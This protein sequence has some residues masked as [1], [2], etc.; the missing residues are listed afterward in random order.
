MGKITLDGQE[1]EY[2]NGVTLDQV[3][4]YHEKNFRPSKPQ[5]EK[6]S[7]GS[8]K[9]FSKG[10]LGQARKSRAG[11]QEFITGNPV[12]YLEQSPMQ[13]PQELWHE[14][15]GSAAAHL[16]KTAIGIGAGSKLGAPFGPMGRAVGGILGAFGS[17]YLTQ[18]GPRFGLDRLGSGAEGAIEALTF[19]TGHKERFD[20]NKQIREHKKPLAGFDERIARQEA[21]LESAKKFTEREKSKAFVDTGSS[22]VEALTRK[23]NEAK[24]ELKGLPSDEAL[25]A[26]DVREGR[27]ILPALPPEKGMGPLDI[28]QKNV[29][30]HEDRLKNIFEPKE[31]MPTHETNINEIMKSEL[32]QKQAALGS[33]YQGFK[34]QHEGRVIKDGYVKDANQIIEELPNPD[35]LQLFGYG[36]ESAEEQA[37]KVNQQLV[38]VTKDVNSLFDNWRSLKRYAQRARGKARA[39]GEDISPD[40]RNSLLNA[41][42]KYDAAASKLEA[43]LKDNGY[44]QSLNKIKDLN[45][46]YANEY[47]PIYDTKAFWYMQKEGKAPPNF[48]NAI[49]GNVRGKE[50]LRDIVKS[51][52]DLLKSSLGQ[53]IKGDP[54]AALEGDKKALLNPYI[55][56]HAASEP[57]FKKLK[58]SLELLPVA[59]KQHTQLINEATRIRTAGDE[60]LKNIKMKK[61]VPVQKQQLK[62]TISK[63]DEYISRLTRAISE[64]ENKSRALNATKAEKLRAEKKI[65]EL[66]EQKDKLGVIKNGLLLTFGTKVVKPLSKIITGNL[67]KGGK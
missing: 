43:T 59:E 14:K 48:L 25:S 21:Q 56:S 49:E 33:E 17:Q 66:K 32:K 3:K 61:E 11:L 1:Y 2:G 60:I 67:K 42:S 65:T 22:K 18:P 20:L 40:E 4:K 29:Q 34:K 13:T 27:P 38:P 58:Q 8:E 24:E 52:P 12:D 31:N 53:A 28:A 45:S 51:N 54:R 64:E 39:M 30:F 37:T 10:I 57:Y 7:V 6:T 16:G 19:G 9:G 55:Q 35:E 62:E 41:A 36:A 63:T 50:I 26:L 5:P 44:E 15:L 23:R 46:R 47:A